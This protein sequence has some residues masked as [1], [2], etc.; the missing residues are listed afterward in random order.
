MMIMITTKGSSA[1]RARKEFPQASALR[2]CSPPL[3]YALST[4]AAL[5]SE[6]WEIPLTL[7]LLPPAF[8]RRRSACMYTPP[9]RFKGKGQTRRLLLA[10]V[11]ACHISAAMRHR[12]WPVGNLED[13]RGAE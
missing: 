6:G 2:L 4:P 13:L 8:A 5:R 3:C 10:T 7:Q 9:P 11:V 1:P 12:G